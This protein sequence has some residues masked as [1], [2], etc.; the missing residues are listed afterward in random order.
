MPPPS[1][2][3]RLARGIV[4]LLQLVPFAPARASG[5][6]SS[7]APPLILEP[8]WLA[9]R[10]ASARHRLSTG[11]IVQ[12]HT[13]CSEFGTSGTAALVSTHG[14]RPRVLTFDAGPLGERGHH[15]IVD[16]RHSVGNVEAGLAREGAGIETHLV[17]PRGARCTTQFGTDDIVAVRVLAIHL[18]SAE[19]K[20]TPWDYFNP[21]TAGS[22][23]FI[24]VARL[25]PGHC[26]QEPV[27]LAVWD[28]ETGRLRPL[29][30]AG[31]APEYGVL[32]D[33]V[34]ITLAGAGPK[35]FLA[36]HGGIGKVRT[37]T[38][39]EASQ[40]VKGNGLLVPETV[41]DPAPPSWLT[42]DE[43]PVLVRSSSE[44]TPHPPKA[45]HCLED[46]QR[47]LLHGGLIYLEEG[48]YYWPAGLHLRRRAP[49]DM[50]TAP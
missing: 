28:L 29:S 39:E 7:P 19:I 15:L 40:A 31:P 24:V 14:G 18:R 22:G 11:A 10:S 33:E 44:R 3:L 23:R 12:F 26:H 47:L 16:S 38:A 5:E 21:A 37:L 42:E 9:P 41:G 30:G 36:V 32:G 49:S 46:E 1:W 17:P 35:R 13:G 8:L 25:T 2:R 27:S 4:V 34:V 43:R 6:E 20:A 45:G 48:I 50:R